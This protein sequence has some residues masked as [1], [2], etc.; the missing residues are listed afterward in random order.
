MKSRITALSLA[1]VTVGSAGP[2][3]AAADFLNFQITNVVQYGNGD[4]VIGTVE[5]IAEPGCANNVL[6]IPAASVAAKGVYAAALVALSSGKKIS[7][8]SEGCYAG[9][10]S[11]N[12]SRGSYFY[13]TP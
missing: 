5:T 2:A 8:R 9:L 7:G 1:V 11:L 3:V 13:L 10:P 6:S 12:N 4:I